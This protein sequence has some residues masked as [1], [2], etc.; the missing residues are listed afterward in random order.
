MQHGDVL[1]ILAN[2]TKLEEYTSRSAQTTLEE[3]LK[4]FIEWFFDY[5]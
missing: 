1:K 3:G 2:T 4:R 5:I